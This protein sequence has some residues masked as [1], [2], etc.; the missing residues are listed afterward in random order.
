MKIIETERLKLV[1][2]SLDDAP[3]IVKLLNEPSFLEYIGDKGV[4][5][6]EDAVKYIKKEFLGSYEQRGYGLMLVKLRDEDVPIG[7]CG[8]KKRNSLDLPEVGYAFLSE[9]QSM[10]YATES[11]RAAIDY[12]R[13]EHGLRRI[14]ALTAP[15]NAASI[16]VL[17]KTGFQFEKMVDLRD[18][19]SENKLFIADFSNE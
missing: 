9:Y 3:F 15:E 4:R 8:I 5:T 6:V 7:I 1:K 18:F 17:K 19:N 13:K 14:A 12:A 16:R 11:A 10:G 2:V